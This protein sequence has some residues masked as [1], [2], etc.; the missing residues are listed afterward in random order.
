MRAH[1]G[2][3][4]ASLCLSVGL[5]AACQ[6]GTAPPATPASPKINPQVA[7]AAQALMQ[8]AATQAET[9]AQG[10]LRVYVHVK[11]TQ[12]DTLSK[13]DHAGLVGAEASAEMGVVQG[14]IAARDLDR[15]AALSCVET[16]SLPRY[17]SPR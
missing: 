8:G 14:W 15:L 4:L 13:L 9:D 10:R 6:A 3:Y 11:D 7:T 17:A 12:A 1:P 16:I 2:R 5:L